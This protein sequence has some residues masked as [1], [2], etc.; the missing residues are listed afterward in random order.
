MADVGPRIVAF[1]VDRRDKRIHNGL[2][3][4]RCHFREG[5]GGKHGLVD[6]KPHFRSRDPKLTVNSPDYERAI[7]FKRSY[8]RA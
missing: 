7:A 1:L 4:Y 8:L 5:F 6:F 3:C 2:S